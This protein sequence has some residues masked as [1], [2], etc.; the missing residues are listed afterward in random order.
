MVKDGGARKKAKQGCRKGWK[1]RYE[2]G[3]QGN[4]KGYREGEDRRE[5]WKVG[6]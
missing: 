5:G 2:A 3:K 4:G 6:I 1:K